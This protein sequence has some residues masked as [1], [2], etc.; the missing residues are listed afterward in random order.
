MPKVADTRMLEI[1]EPVTISEYQ[2]AWP[3]AFAAEQRR[4]SKA[5]RVPASVLEHIGSTA[6]PGLMAKPTIDLM[7][8]VTDFPP[9]P[10]FLGAIER[11]GY[12]SLGEAGVSGRL[13]FRLRGAM[14]SNLHVV[15]MNGVHW[16]NNLALREHLRGDPDAR[17]RYARAKLAV[18]ASGS[19]SL[20]AYSAAKAAVVSGLLAEALAARDAK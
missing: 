14:P 9:H 13:Y 15:L 18:Q 20:L 2:A 7:L 8:S 4:L 1:D 19:G 12:E 3:D 16:V 11:S 5:L 17:D 6:V 10:G